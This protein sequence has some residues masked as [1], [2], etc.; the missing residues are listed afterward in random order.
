MR[1]NA[2]RTRLI[3]VALFFVGILAVLIWRML[4]LMVTDRQFL[5]G[6]GNARSLRVV[7]IPAFRGMIID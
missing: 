5:Q 2:H 6:Q 3:V 4:D 7:D 1:K